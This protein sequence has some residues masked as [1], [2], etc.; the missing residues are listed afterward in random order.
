MRRPSVAFLA[1]L[2][3]A[4][5]A[6]RPPIVGVGPLIPAIQDDLRVS[7]AVAG[8][9]GTIPVL[10]MGLFALPAPALGGR[11]GSRRA[12]V[13][14]LAL[15]GVFGIGRAA[16]P[17]AAAVL[18]LTF[19]VGIG[20]GFAQALMPAAVKERFAGRPAFATG[21]Y[22]LGINIGSAIS[23][24][25]AVP[26]ADTAGG[27][28]W[29]VAFFAIATCALV[30]AWWWL[31]RAEAP[32]RQADVTRVRLPWRSGLA[33]RLVGI[34]GA[35][36]CFFYGL[37]SWL[38]DAYVEHGWS[39]GKAGALLAVLN[40]A[41]LVTTMIIPWLADRR[42]SR[43][44]YLVLFSAALAGSAAGFAAVPGGAWAWAVVAGLCVGAMFPLVMTLPVDVGR[45]PADVGATAGLMLGVGYTI[46]AVAPLVLGAAR[47]ATGTFTTTLWLICG[48]GVVLFAL[49]ASMSAARIGRGV[50]AP[51]AP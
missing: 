34:F 29:S 36:A 2:F 12:I 47:D 17:G 42:G 6:L 33:W 45:R 13:V 4:G 1:G 32:H 41:A 25:L 3:L 9:L 19:G 31:T 35:M 5:L 28:R 15:I 8:L 39:D 48:A 20:L 44:L 43:R 30:L 7:H 10:C 26:I 38:P 16:A 46:G 21:I 24:A 27:W 40:I 22:V 11:Y 50:D 49:C 18:V 23:S 51:A 14:C 37:N